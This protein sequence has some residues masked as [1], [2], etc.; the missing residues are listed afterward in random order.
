MLRLFL[1]ALLAVFTLP[2][3]AATFIKYEASGIGTFWRMEGGAILEDDVAYTLTAFVPLSGVCA[4]PIECSTGATSVGLSQSFEL[5]GL[6][7]NASLR[8][9]HS[10][11]GFPTSADGFV[12]GDL[13]AGTSWGAWFGP[14]T[15]LRVETVEADQPAGGR[16]ILST[17]PIPEPATWVM[18]IA[19]F[20]LLGGALRR[21]GAQLSIRSCTSSR[22]IA[23]I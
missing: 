4:P 15:N 1:A 12:S 11:S 19:G 8:F 2:A 22:A 5:T 18:M 7:I 23:A 20:G 9:D 14:F 6:Q 16:L 3:S 21:H 17:S 13:Y 10:L